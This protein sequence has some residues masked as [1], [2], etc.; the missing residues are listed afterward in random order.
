MTG[1]VTVVLYFLRLGF[2][3]VFL[4]ASVVSGFTT[5]AAFL[6]GVTQLKDITGVTGVGRFARA[7][8]RARVC[9]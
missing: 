8:A 6:I 4:S 5:G 3:A 1:A 7:R 9:V 2:L